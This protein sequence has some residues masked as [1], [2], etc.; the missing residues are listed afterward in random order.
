MNKPKEI[1][2][3]RINA[4]QAIIVAM[5]SGFFGVIGTLIG[6]GYFNATPNRQTSEQRIDIEK[7]ILLDE[8]YVARDSLGKYF[9]KKIQRK[10]NYDYKNS[11]FKIAIALVLSGF[12]KDESGNCDVDG[13][14]FLNSPIKPVA[15]YGKLPKT[16]RPDEWK[17]RY[18]PSKLSMGEIKAE[19]GET[20]GK[21]VFIQILTD[22]N[23]CV[24]D[25]N[26]TG[27]ADFRI[28]VTDNKNK[29]IDQETAKI[30]IIE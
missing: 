9:L 8:S 1:E 7:L 30:R 28:I 15:D 2:V 14:I 10:T 19:I 12:C 16:V 18:I 23:K 27:D 22:F 13:D 21:M 25:T 6:T 20:E 24:I 11:A 4:K 5:I 17:T 3:A 29:A 26:V